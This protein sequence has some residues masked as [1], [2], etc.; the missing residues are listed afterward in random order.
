MRIISEKKT[1]PVKGRS[2]R[3]YI[4]NLSPPASGGKTDGQPVRRV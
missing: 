4:I 3:E 1:C 2:A